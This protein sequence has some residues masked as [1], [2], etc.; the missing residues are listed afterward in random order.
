MTNNADPF[1]LDIRRFGPCAADVLSGDASGSVVGVFRRCFYVHLDDSYICMGNTDFSD[2]PINVVTSAP[3]TTDW[4]A[5]GLTSGAPAR[6]SNHRLRL[7]PHLTFSLNRARI[8]RPARPGIAPVSARSLTT[9]RRFFA[10]SPPVAGLAPQ[11]FGAPV[12]ALPQAEHPLRALSLWLAQNL[13]A[14]PDHQQEPPVEKLL[15]L[16]PGLT[17]SGD[18]FLAGVLI[19]LAALGETRARLHLAGAIRTHAPAATNPISAQHLYAATAGLGGAAIHDLFAAL[20]TDN[21]DSQR[22]ALK[23]LVAVGHTS[24]WDALA[25]LYRTLNIWQSARQNEIIAA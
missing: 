23:N 17:P 21:P 4:Q 13:T 7:G 22:A 8:W 12:A 5:S 9:L 14:H 25:G 20:Q 6:L 11:V 19:T 2:G 3:H 18:D 16:G 24:G 15:G 1:S 10:A